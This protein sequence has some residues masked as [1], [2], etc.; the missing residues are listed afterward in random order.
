MVGTG[1]LK[2]VV[3]CVEI[4]GRIRKRYRGVVEVESWGRQR[5]YRG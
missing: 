5:G 2:N 4:G 1:G 3:C